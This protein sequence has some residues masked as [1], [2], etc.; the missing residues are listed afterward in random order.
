MKLVND[1]TVFLN[2]LMQG[3]QS[4]RIGGHFHTLSFIRPQTC[5]FVHILSW[6]L[7]VTRAGGAGVT[8]WLAGHQS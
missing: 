8:D 7:P 2:T 1:F 4:Y 6:L 3:Q 5:P